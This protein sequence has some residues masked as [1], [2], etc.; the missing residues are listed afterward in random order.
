[1]DLPMIVAY[2]GDT[3]VEPIPGGALGTPGKTENIR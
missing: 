2:K 1:M 3:R